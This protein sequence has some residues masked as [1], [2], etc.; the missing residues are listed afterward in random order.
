MTNHCTSSLS[1]NSTIALFKSNQS[2]V[3]P[4]KLI[5]ILTF[6]SCL[7]LGNNLM[8][9][10]PSTFS[11]LDQSLKPKKTTSNL[12]CNS[13]MASRRIWSKPCLSSCHRSKHNHP[14]LLCGPTSSPTSP[15]SLP[16]P[17]PASP[18]KSPLQSCKK[19]RVMTPCLPA[20]SSPITSPSYIPPPFPPHASPFLP[21]MRN[22]GG[23]PLQL[24]LLPHGC[25]DQPQRE[26]DAPFY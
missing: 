6:S 5:S 18:P 15:L 16:L 9:S 21:H 7:T 22:R 11:P 24:L 17:S 4:P 25:P 10:F 8:I 12:P 3:V 19:Y 23:T 1:H 13:I 2:H 26:K 14:P 20:P